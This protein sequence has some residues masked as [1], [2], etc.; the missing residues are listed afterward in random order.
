M[1]TVG[2]NLAI[3]TLDQIKERGPFGKVFEVEAEFVVFGQGVKVGEVG[4]ED[5]GRVEWSEGCHDVKKPQRRPTLSASAS[6][7]SSRLLSSWVTL[8]LS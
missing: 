4:F 1:Y 3:L 5:V 7:A 6:H 2:G 8:L